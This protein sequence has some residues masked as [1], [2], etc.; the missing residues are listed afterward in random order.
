MAA[1]TSAR[2]RVS[3]VRVTDPVFSVK[4]RA[5]KVMD[6][7]RYYITCGDLWV[8]GACWRP[9]GC[10]RGPITSVERVL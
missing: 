9:K 1:S 6:G 5:F 2:V 4:P 7:E 8:A 3:L 10:P